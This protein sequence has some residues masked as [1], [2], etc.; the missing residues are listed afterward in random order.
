V[1]QLDAKKAHFLEL[2]K[3]P[4]K[5][6]KK[7]AAPAASSNGNHQTAAQSDVSNAAVSEVSAS[8]QKD[9]SDSKAAEGSK[10]LSNG[11]HA[12]EPAGVA[13][14]EKETKSVSKGAAAAADGGLQQ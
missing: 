13:A 2:R 4:P 8:G 14:E 1:L 9:S 5:A 12:A 7:A 3:N 11:A 6:E 10:P